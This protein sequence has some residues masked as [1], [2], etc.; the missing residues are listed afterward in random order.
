RATTRIASANALSSSLRAPVGTATYRCASASMYA[1]SF[2]DA[3]RARRF[4]SC[5]ASYAATPDAESLAALML[6][7]SAYATPHQHIAH[8]GSAATDARKDRIASP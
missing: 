3:P 2:G 1:R 6:G 8:V 5:T 7:P 4:A